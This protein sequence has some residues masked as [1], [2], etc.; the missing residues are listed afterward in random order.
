MISVFLLILCSSYIRGTRIDEIW[1]DEA[2]IHQNLRDTTR[3][4]KNF[5]DELRINKN[6]RNLASTMQG[7]WDNKD[8]LDK[9]EEEDVPPQ[10]RHSQISGIFFEVNVTRFPHVNVVC[11]LYLLSAF[12]RIEFKTREQKEAA[13]LS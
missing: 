1:R 7:F 10:D 11:I 6:Y 9:E 3:N 12:Y 5:Q 13:L 4:S 8:Q 2:L